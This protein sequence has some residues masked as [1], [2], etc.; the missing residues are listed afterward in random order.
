VRV[1]PCGQPSRKTFQPGFVWISD[2]NA[3][4]TGRPRRSIVSAR[5]VADIHHVASRNAE[6]VP[7]FPDAVRLVDTRQRNVNTIS[8]FISTRAR[9]SYH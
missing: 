3:Y 4:G 1:S 6:D 7:Q 5:E 2:L 9:V 8:V